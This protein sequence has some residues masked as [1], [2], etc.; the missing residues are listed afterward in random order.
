MSNAIIIIQIMFITIGMIALGMF[1]NYILGLRKEVLREMRQKALNLQERMRNAQLLGDPQMMIQLQKESTQFM[2]LM[3]K[4]QLVPMCL[5]CLVFIGIFAILGIFYSPYEGLLPFPLLFFGDGWIAIYIIFSISFSLL[6]YGVKKIYKKVI[7][8]ET[9]TQSSFREIMS[10]ISPTYQSQE[11]R[12]Q[13]S[14]SPQYQLNDSEGK[15]GISP[16]RKDS[17]KE[18]IEE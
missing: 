6:I 14:S 1:L 7:G 18:R 3:M 15:N 2:K 17:W 12:F 10:I 5:R 11:P 4:K 16:A 9:K 8:K 13:I